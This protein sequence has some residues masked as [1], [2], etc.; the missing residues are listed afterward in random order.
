MALLALLPK[1][2]LCVLA[3][4]GL[5]GAVGLAGPELCGAAP[6]RTRHALWLLPLLG[7]VACLLL[8]YRGMLR[9]FALGW[10]NQASDRELA[11]R[12]SNDTR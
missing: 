3:C 1:C 5:G 7:A 6:D 12:R 9:T 2:L 10:S 11:T 8:K 4:I